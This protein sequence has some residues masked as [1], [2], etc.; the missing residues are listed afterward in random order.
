MALR[1]KDEGV[2]L[3]DEV[4]VGE[5]RGSI[6]IAS[7]TTTC[8][9]L[10]HTAP[11]LLYPTSGRY[12]VVSTG[13]TPA[14]TSCCAPSCA[15]S[16]IRSFVA[17]HHCTPAR[18]MSTSMSSLAPATY[19]QVS[20][21]AASSGR[22]L[23]NNPAD[24]AVHI[25]L[26][27]ANSTLMELIAHAIV[28][29]QFHAVSCQIFCAILERIESREA[30]GMVS[31]SSQIAR[32]CTPHVAR[33]FVCLPEF[34]L[35]E[36]LPKS[37]AEQK[38]D[39]DL[40]TAFSYFAEDEALLH[41]LGCNVPIIR[42]N[43]IV[44]SN[45]RIVTGR[46]YLTNAA[47]NISISEDSFEAQ[48][49]TGQYTV[50][51]VS[52]SRCQI[53]LG[54]TYTDALDRAN[55]YKVGKFLLG[56]KLFARPDC[57]TAPTHRAADQQETS[58]T[59]CHRCTRNTSR[60]MLQMIC[61][62]TDNMNIARTIKLHWLLLRQK[63]LEDQARLRAPQ[64]SRRFMH[65]A[66]RALIAKCLPLL[67]RVP[68]GSFSR[69]P[70][71]SMP[72]VARLFPQYAAGSHEH[73]P[74]QARS[75]TGD[76]PCASGCQCPPATFNTAPMTVSLV[77]TEAWSAVLKERIGMLVWPQVLQDS[78]LP[79]TWG[80]AMLP[81]ES[82]DDAHLRKGLTNVL[83]FIDTV[84]V[85]SQ[86][87]APAGHVGLEKIPALLKALPS[88]A[89]MSNVGP[90]AAMRVVARTV[91]QEWVLRAGPTETPLVGADAE[92]LLASMVAIG[93]MG[94][95][96][97]QY[98]RQLL[99]SGS[100]PAPPP[101][102]SASQ[103]T[104]TGSMPDDASSGDLTQSL[105]AES[106]PDTHRET[107]T[108]G[109]AAGPA[110]GPAVGRRRLVSIIHGY[111]HCFLTPVRYVP[112]S[113]REPAATVR[114]P[115]PATARENHNPQTARLFGFVRRTPRAAPLHPQ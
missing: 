2:P 89:S 96:E 22:L 63:E 92:V 19:T 7:A 101:S 21:V 4:D 69:C 26:E 99:Q 15:P 37:G 1:A 88:V 85:I 80:A 6:P 66:R 86:R 90:V 23:A 5:A 29:R 16:G 20:V 94:Q 104:E 71:V 58:G 84:S 39:A 9:G 79:S 91:R 40:N 43:D 83:R 75:S 47:Y 57:C 64:D 70:R 3:L 95:S 114:E 72:R 59:M 13:P 108:A 45:Y 74:Q 115:Q 33:T 109:Q 61:L 30:V 68:P 46:A 113:I 107:T 31:P 12:S 65:M 60:S 102:S 53:R 38:E 11:Q 62:M 14:T 24:D 28:D 54:V 81:L 73:T 25:I 48:Y 41:C 32:L 78:M 36:L 77:H 10:A 42:A 106:H 110:V 17:A 34:S 112:A 103:I 27:F 51:H 82:F 35:A 44:S 100:V 52:C 8:H 76:S 18:L 111:I 105:R 93:G 55:R 97:Q 50:K 87:R 56:Q 49:T 98:L 67:R